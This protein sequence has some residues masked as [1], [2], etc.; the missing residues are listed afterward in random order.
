MRN[1]QPLVT[2]ESQ[3]LRKE[4]NKTRVINTYRDVE[5]ARRFYLLR[6]KEEQDSQTEI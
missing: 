2:N 6:L 3:D 4:L 1:T 5:R